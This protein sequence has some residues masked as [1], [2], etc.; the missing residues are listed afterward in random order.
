MD[1]YTFVCA[2]TGY[3]GA[4]INIAGMHSDL[5]L[6]NNAESVQHT[7][8]FRHCKNIMAGFKRLYAANT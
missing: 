3:N 6:K 1:G 8:Y 5:A 2:N 4:E 7:N